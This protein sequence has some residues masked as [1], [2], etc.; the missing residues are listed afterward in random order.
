MKK[1]RVLMITIELPY[2]ATSG[3]RMKS[4]NMLKVLAKHYELGL[5]APL[6]YGEELVPEFSKQVELTE[7]HHDQVDIQRTA[8]N[9]VK[10][11]L[12]A[13]PLNVLRSGSKKLK[14]AVA[15]IADNYDI[16]LLDHYE[17][18]Q[19]LPDD[20]QGKVILHTHNA[21]YL[22]W[23]RYATTGNNFAIR[24][25]CALEARRVKAYELKAV[26]RADLV[27]AAPN[28]IDSL[29]AIGGQR[30]KF[31]ET[32]HLG[33]DS[34]LSLPCLDFNRTDE[35][36]LYVGTLSWEANIDG[37]LWFFREVWPEVK[38]GHPS[39]RFLIAG[40]NP[41]ARI[42]QAAQTLDGVELLGFVDDLEPLFNRAR[43]FMAPLLF[44][45][46]IK[47]KVLNAMCRGLPTITTPVGAEGLAVENMTHL[48]I[49][50]DA[51]QMVD[52][53]KQLL[54]DNST[55]D[56]LRDQSRTLVEQRYTWKRVLGYM[57]DEM[58]KLAQVQ[59]ID[60]EAI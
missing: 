9:L 11:Y 4:W 53:I 54:S 42:V 29:V 51:P 56:R 50:E 26:E 1:K 16:I 32:F 8:L 23:D 31:R 39:L 40:G 18:F 21:T 30:E 20:Y 33:D 5:I 22:M 47:V 28:D 44:G 49:S 2:P 55:W 12:Q 36:L 37:L 57:T 24:S 35:S 52:A 10:S 59:P 43:L 60:Q 25:A 15:E 7:F 48:S 27:F 46:G 3:G 45:S 19:Y 6:K 41:D 38:A 58:D 13:G 17:S 14:L 34:Q